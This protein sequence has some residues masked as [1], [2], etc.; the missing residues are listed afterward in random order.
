MRDSPREPW[1]RRDEIVTFKVN[2]QLAITAAG[3]FPGSS[4]SDGPDGSLVLNLNTGKAKAEIFAVPRPGG[5]FSVHAL[6]LNKYVI[7]SVQ[8]NDVYSYSLLQID[9]GEAVVSSLFYDKIDRKAF[10]ATK[11]RIASEFKIGN[12][13]YFD[14]AHFA[15]KQ[16]E[17]RNYFAQL[18]NSPAGPQIKFVPIQN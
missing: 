10:L 15:N 6:G 16:D 17:M 3:L 18:T 5:G 14:P 1:K 2:P 9:K 8:E 4:T 12:V 11:G 7:V 13:C